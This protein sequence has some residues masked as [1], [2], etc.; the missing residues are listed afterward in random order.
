MRI[1]SCYFTKE[2][3][4]AEERYVGH[5]TL[6]NCLLDIKLRSL[7]LLAKQYINER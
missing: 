2:L 3:L 4:N 7:N 1:N 6:Q 5:L